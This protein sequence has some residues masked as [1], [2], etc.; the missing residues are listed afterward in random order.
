MISIGNLSKEINKQLRAYANSTEAEVDELAEK[1]ADEGVTLLRSNSPERTG[2]YAEGWKKSKVGTA[3]V[4]H[5]ETDYRLTH[6]LEKGHTGR[7]GKPVNA[8][9]HIEKVENII[10]K[11]FINGVEKSL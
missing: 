3:F 9:P 5:N 1:F 6:L 2:D 11:K 10:N 8:R 4:V 7:D